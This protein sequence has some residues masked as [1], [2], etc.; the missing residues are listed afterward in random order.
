MSI[1]RFMLYEVLKRHPEARPCGKRENLAKSFTYHRDTGWQ[2]WFNY[3]QKDNKDTSGLLTENQL[4]KEVHNYIK[5]KAY[6]CF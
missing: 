1:K 2:L 3:D 4:L 6:L 5:D